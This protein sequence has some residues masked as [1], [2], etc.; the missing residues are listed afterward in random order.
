MNELGR[1]LSPQHL[2]QMDG[3]PL[4]QIAAA[5]VAAG[6]VPLECHVNDQMSLW[7]RF[8]SWFSSKSLP[9]AAA[10][11]SAFTTTTTFSS[12]GQFVVEKSH[13]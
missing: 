8:F 4:G 10:A 9:A 11:C 7:L 5:A 12:S 3:W 1:W 6:S 13:E 2:D